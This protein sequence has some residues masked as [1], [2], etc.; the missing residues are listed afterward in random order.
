[1]L[2]SIL[3]LFSRGEERDRLLGDKYQFSHQRA[4]ALQ[5]WSLIDLQRFRVR[6]GTSST[7]TCFAGGLSR[8]WSVSR[9]QQNDIGTALTKQQLCSGIPSKC[10][11]IDGNNN[12]RR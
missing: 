7:L 6:F 12:D 9:H 8:E 3:D 1:M 10:G 5:R 11:S 4:A 2:E